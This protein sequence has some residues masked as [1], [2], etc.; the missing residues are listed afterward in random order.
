MSTPDT[1]APKIFI[2][3]AW[4]SPD[5]NERV[6]GLADRLFGDGIEVIIDVYSLREG[7]DIIAFMEK[8]ATQKDISKVLIISDKKYAEKADKRTG[9][10]GTE[11]QIISSEVYSSIEQ[12]KFIPIVFELDDGK[13][14]LPVYL[15]N[16]YFIDMSTLESENENYERLIRN[17]Y[18]KPQLKKPKLGKTPAFILEDTQ[19]PTATAGRERTVRDAI[20]K[21]RPYATNTINDYLGAISDEINNIPPSKHHNYS[22]LEDEALKRIQDFTST[23]DEFIGLL[24]FLAGHTTPGYLTEPLFAFFESV[25]KALSVPYP[26]GG[27]TIPPNESI[28]AAQF[29]TYE[30]FLHTVSALIRK[31]QF[32]TVNTML[33]REY[34]AP[35]GN[36]EMAFDSFACFR[37]YLRVLEGYR[38]AKVSLVSPTAGLVKDRALGYVSFDEIMQTEFILTLFS[39]IHKQSLWFPLTLTFAGI[40]KTFPLFQRAESERV[41]DGL[42]EL[43]AVEDKD[44]FVEMYSIANQAN[45]LGRQIQFPNAHFHLKYEQLGNFGKLATRP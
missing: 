34:H 2:S 17:I 7:H 5:H 43:F 38:K 23:R 25:T 26:K 4:S 11:S 24:D 35:L 39:F 3:Y 12:E 1:A 8:L 18:N 27:G 42:R 20:L 9:G 41:F 10:V 30:L 22:E 36:G 32:K 21:S 16:R 28:E 45:P 31:S 15:K 37:P 19:Q 33:S 6:R 14:A 13:P 40:G 44:Q 29:I